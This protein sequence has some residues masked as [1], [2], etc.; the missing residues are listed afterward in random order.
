MKRLRNFQKNYLHLNALGRFVCLDDL[1]RYTMNW[2]LG[3]WWVT[4]KLAGHVF[5]VRRIATPWESRFW[6]WAMD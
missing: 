1:G 6:G 3:P 4:L 5:G 2:D